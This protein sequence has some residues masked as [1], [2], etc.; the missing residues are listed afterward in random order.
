VPQA[1]VASDARET[2]EKYLKGTFTNLGQLKHEC[3]NFTDTKMVAALSTFCTTRSPYCFHLQYES[4][5]RRV[6]ILTLLINFEGAVRENG[7]LLCLE[8]G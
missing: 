6:Q 2:L 3:V 4:N 1:A 8:R 7:E 5:R